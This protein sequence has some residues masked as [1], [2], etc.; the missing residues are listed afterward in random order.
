MIRGFNKYTRYGMIRLLLWTLK[1]VKLQSLLPRFSIFFNLCFGLSSS[2]ALD[3][4]KSKY[5]E[6]SKYLADHAT[7]N[8]LVLLLYSSFY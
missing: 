4:L 5:I 6:I 3:L 2:V 7:H 1:T 8:Y